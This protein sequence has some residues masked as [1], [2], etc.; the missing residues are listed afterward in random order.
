LRLRFADCLREQA[1]R[2]N[3]SARHRP[4]HR[5]RRG[6]FEAMVLKKAQRKKGW[7]SLWIA[8]LFCICRAIKPPLQRPCFLP[9]HAESGGG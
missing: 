6:S 9:Q 2:V 4:F 3:F 1:S 8:N 5:G 7:Q